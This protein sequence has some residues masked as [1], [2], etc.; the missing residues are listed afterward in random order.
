MYLLWLGFFLLCLIKLIIRSPKKTTVQ[1]VVYY[2]RLKLFGKK[3]FSNSAN[4]KE[5]H[6]TFRVNGHRLCDVLHLNPSTTKAST[7]QLKLHPQQHPFKRMY[8]KSLPTLSSICST[9]LYC[10]VSSCC[11]TIFPI[12]LWNFTNILKWFDLSNGLFFWAAASFANRIA[13]DLV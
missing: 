10:W 12:S 2:F 5:I 9:N 8:C 4:F 3:N 6:S 1:K 11:R 7:V 13:C